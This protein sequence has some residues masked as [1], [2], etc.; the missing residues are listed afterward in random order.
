MEIQSILSNSLYIS[1]PEVKIN[2]PF[3]ESELDIVIHFYQIEYG[4]SD[5]IWLPGQK[6]I[7]A[8]SWL[9]LGSLAFEETS[10]HMVRK[11]KQTY[12]EVHV[13]TACQ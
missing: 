10:C 11:L 9:Y 1:L 8:S 6:S 13:A 5:G 2:S 7:M 3:L 12:S 4:K